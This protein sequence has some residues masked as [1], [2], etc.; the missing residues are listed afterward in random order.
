MELII[1]RVRKLV[2]PRPVVIYCGLSFLITFLFWAVWQTTIGEVPALRIVGVTRQFRWQLPFAISRWWD[3][4]AIPVL[5]ALYFFFKDKAARGAVKKER[6]SWA[7]GFSA[8]LGFLCT[9]DTGM[10]HVFAMAVFAGLV[11][12]WLLALHKNPF[13][14][15]QE[16]VV[17]GCAAGLSVMVGAGIVIGFFPGLVLGTLLVA[18]FLALFPASFFATRLFIKFKKGIGSNDSTVC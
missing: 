15:F 9:A 1:Q 6:L 13:L 14:H 10:V 16:T 7:V 3:I 12:G 11:A 8:Y 2:K 5:A 17:I 4:P 18:I